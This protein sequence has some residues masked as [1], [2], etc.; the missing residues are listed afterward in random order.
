MKPAAEIMKDKIN[1]IEFKN[2][3]IEIIANV[4]AKGVKESE[5]IKE[6]IN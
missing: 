4:T 5:Q 6:I 3:S 1:N 2:P